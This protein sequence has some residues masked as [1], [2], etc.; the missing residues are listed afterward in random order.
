M[1]MVQ[2]QHSLRAQGRCR[3][4]KVVPS[5]VFLGR[6]FLFSCSDTF[7]VGCIVYP[8]CTA[9]QTDRRTTL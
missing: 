3:G 4:L 6:H 2:E 9:S 7:A 1:S 5:C 8:H